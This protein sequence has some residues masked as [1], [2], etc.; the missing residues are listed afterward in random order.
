MASLVH[1]FVPGEN[2]PRKRTEFESKPESDFSG[3]DLG[4]R[5]GRGAES[6]SPKGGSDLL[7]TRESP[8]SKEESDLLW[9]QESESKAGGAQF[10][11]D[12]RARVQGPRGGS[13]L[14]WTGEPNSP[15]WQGI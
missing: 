6:P 9:T 7:W 2:E 11:L 14:L 5:S 12:R 10:A 3:A 8:E 15:I 4:V 1:C 13:D